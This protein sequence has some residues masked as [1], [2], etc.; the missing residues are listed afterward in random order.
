MT[1][2]VEF[3][4]FEGINMEAEMYVQ[5]AMMAS[6]VVKITGVDEVIKN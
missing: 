4:T 2:E 5:V 1:F 3:Y 6:K